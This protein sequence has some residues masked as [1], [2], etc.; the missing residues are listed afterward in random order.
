MNF[1]LNDTVCFTPTEHAQ[2][3]WDKYQEDLP[4][5]LKTPLPTRMQFWQL[6]VVFGPGMFLGANHPIEMSVIV[7]ES[8]ECPICGCLSLVPEQ[9]LE[10]GGGPLK[11]SICH[12]ALFLEDHGCD[13]LGLRKA[14]RAD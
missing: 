7:E 4:E 6:M 14:T 8:L 3:Y 9:C 1:N 13:G 11:C 5:K 10:E 2:S 12:A